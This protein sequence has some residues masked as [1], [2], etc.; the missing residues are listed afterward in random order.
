MGAARTMVQNMANDVL[1]AHGEE[2]VGMCWV[3]SSRSVPLRSSF[4]AA[5][6]MIANES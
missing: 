1:A 6:H 4:N 5:L 3:I 2:R